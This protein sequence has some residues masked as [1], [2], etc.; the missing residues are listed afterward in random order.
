MNTATAQKTL[1]DVQDNDYFLVDPDSTVQYRKIAYED[2]RIF[3]RAVCRSFRDIPAKETDLVYNIETEAERSARYEAQRAEENARRKAINEERIKV[4]KAV[5]KALGWCMVPQKREE[6][7]SEPESVREVIKSDNGLELSLSLGAYHC[8]DKWHISGTGV[9]INCA[10]TKTPEQI[11]KDI[12]RRMLADLQAATN[13]A[14]E[15]KAQEEA[16][17]K[18]TNDT[19]QACIDV[20]GGNTS[21]NYKNRLYWQGP[22]C[23]IN[24][25]SVRFDDFY[26]DKDDALEVLALLRKIKGR[27][28]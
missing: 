4:I 10:Q 20:T 24:G 3:I 17:K 18:L 21:T 13:K 8:R 11:A 1:A 19:L 9:S 22:T 6:S 5:A 12:T 2:G 26:L 16:Y 27:K 28:K 25:E 14:N 7:Y 23:E 15:K